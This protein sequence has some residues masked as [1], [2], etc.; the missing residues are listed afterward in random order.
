MIKCNEGKSEIRGNV[1]ILEA[2]LTVILKDMREILTDTYGN[3]T[4]ADK[5]IDRILRL[6]RMSDDDLEKELQNSKKNLSERLM[7]LIMDL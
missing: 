5:M 7:D 3:E 2:E 6:S 4:F 1:I